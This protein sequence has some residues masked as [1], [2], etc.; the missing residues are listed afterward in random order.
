MSKM[1]SAAG[2]SWYLYVKKLMV[3]ASLNTQTQ[4]EGSAAAVTQH[5]NSRLTFIHSDMP[6]TGRT[7]RSTRRKTSPSFPSASKT[8]WPTLGFVFIPYSS[9]RHLLD[10]LIH[11]S[12]FQKYLQ[13]LKSQRQNRNKIC[14]TPSTHTS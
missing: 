6:T 4:R 3:S 7:A 13:T 5:F 14:Q 12:L 11:S 9:D 8:R 1:L 10:A 2:E